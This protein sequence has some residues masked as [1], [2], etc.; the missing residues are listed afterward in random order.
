MAPKISRGIWETVG[1]QP[2]ARKS[3]EP[4]VGVFY[5]VFWRPSAGEVNRIS[6][7]KEG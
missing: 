3:S 4:E 6:R 7:K 1:A 5:Q 2:D